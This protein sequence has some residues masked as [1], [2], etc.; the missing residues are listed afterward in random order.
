MN[1][2]LAG[3]ALPAHLESWRGSY[4]GRGYGAIEPDAMPEPFLGALAPRPAGVFLALNPGQACLRF[5]GRDGIFAEEI[6]R[7]GGSFAKWAATWPYLRDPWIA[8]NGPNRH[9]CA[10]LRFLRYWTCDSDLSA[11]AMT[12]FEMYPWHST[13]VTASMKRG[14]ARDMI[15]QYVWRPVAE[16]GAPVFAF[17]AP[18]FGI[19]KSTPELR[20]VAR[21]GVGGR[22]YGSRVPSRAVIVMQDRDGLTVIAEK[23]SGGAGP[24]NRDETAILRDALKGIL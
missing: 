24:P 2:F 8:A 21:L 15:R 22:D 14:D 19:L 1:G 3:D 20:V 7:S 5:Q 23:H 16:L 12:A 13:R 10:R 6:R 4:R 17:G 9:H 18:W 11:S